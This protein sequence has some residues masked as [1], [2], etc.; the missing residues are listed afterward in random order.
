[1]RQGSFARAV[2]GNKPVAFQPRSME[3]SSPSDPMKPKPLTEVQFLD[4]LEK[5]LAKVMPDLNLRSL[6]HEEVTKEIR[7]H[8]HL[9]TFTKF[10]ETG[11]VPTASA[12]ARVTTTD[13]TAAKMGRSMKNR[14]II[15]RVGR[16]LR[17]RRRGG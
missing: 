10:C 5:A 7:L 4:L 9:A 17:E 2:K 15:A 11:S 6:I 12:P 16:S 13:S 3:K 1:M 8:N 14:A